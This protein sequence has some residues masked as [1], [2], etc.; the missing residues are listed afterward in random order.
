MDMIHLTRAGYE[1]LIEELEHIKKVKRKEITEALA[2]ARSLGDLKENAEYHAA[3]E[4]MSYNEAR[5]RELEDKLSRV[6]II[7]DTKMDPSKAYI[8][9]KVTLI[10]L[11]TDDEIEYTLVSQDEANAT[12]GLISTTSPVGQALLGHKVGDEISIT[13]PAGDLSYKITKISR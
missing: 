1:K 6:E 11:E 7:D 8:G 4:A 3:K 13:V 10:D 12:E 5:I 9:A 2:H